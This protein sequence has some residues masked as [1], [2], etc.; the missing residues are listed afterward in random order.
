LIYGIRM[1]Q[2]KIARGHN[3]IELPVPRIGR[4]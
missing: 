4:A 1:L 2:R 3:N